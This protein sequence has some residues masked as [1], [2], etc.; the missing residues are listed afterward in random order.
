MVPSVFSQP[1]P[2]ISSRH[3]RCSLLLSPRAAARRSP[4]AARRC[5]P[6]PS[7]AAAPRCRCLP[8]RPA[9]PRPAPPAL[10]RRVGRSPPHPAGRAGRCPA[11]SPRQPRRAGRSHGP[12]GHRGN[13]AL[14]GARCSLRLPLPVPRGS[15]LPAPSAA[16]PPR[17]TI[18]AIE[19]RIATGNFR[20]F[21]L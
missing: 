13:T 4:A 21:V 5:P 17:S 20:V 19:L 9:P 3:W 18:F 15:S 12:A 11:V 10:P 8:R 14:R 7:P 2:R 6:R 1:A 16:S